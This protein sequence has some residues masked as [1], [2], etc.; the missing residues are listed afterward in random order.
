MGFPSDLE[1]MQL[2]LE[3]MR[4]RADVVQVA[5]CLRPEHREDAEFFLAVLGWTLEAFIADA[6]WSECDGR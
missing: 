2:R 6:Y 5:T 4:D 3:A 1:L